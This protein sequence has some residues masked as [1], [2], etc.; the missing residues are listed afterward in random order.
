MTSDK[1]MSFKVERDK[2]LRTKEILTK[3]YEA[4]VKGKVVN[5]A[6]IPESFR[7]LLK[8]FQA[9]GLD[10]QIQ[11][12]EDEFVDIQDLERDDEEDEPITVDRLDASG[13]VIKEENDEELP[14]PEPEDPEG[15]E[16]EEEDEF[17][18]DSLDDLEYPGEDLEE[19]GDLL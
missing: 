13:N 3:V 16:E 10:I 2:S 6:G 18:G 12:Q 17:E 4:L 19:D 15:F 7:V 9:L 1:T 14:P 8:E 11:N 5:Q